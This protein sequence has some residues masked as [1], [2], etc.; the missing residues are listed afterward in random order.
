[1]LRRMFGPKTQEVTGSWKN[2]C[3]KT[4]IATVLSNSTRRTK[5]KN[6]ILIRQEVHKI[7]RKKA[8]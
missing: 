6:T 2:N 7:K 5:Y 3:P 8:K 1:M 4:D